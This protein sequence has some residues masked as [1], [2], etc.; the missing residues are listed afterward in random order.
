M[1]KLLALL[2]II[3]GC[4]GAWWGA[5]QL[6]SWTAR[7]AMAQLSARLPAGASLTYADMQ[8]SLLHRQVVLS[9]FKAASGQEPAITVTADR[10]VISGLP[11][12]SQHDIKLGHVELGNLT[13]TGP[14]S[15]SAQFVE[16]DQP[17]YHL[18]DQLLQGRIDWKAG[19]F[20]GLT[21]R[22]IQIQKTVPARTIA[23]DE[24]VLGGFKDGL[25][26]QAELKGLAASTPDPLYG[27]FNSVKVAMLNAQMVAVDRLM[28]GYGKINLFAPFARA[29]IQSATATDVMLG[30]NGED[31]SSRASITFT[32]EG[33]ASGITTSSQLSGTVKNMPVALIP[34]EWRGLLTKTGYEDVSGTFNL[35]TQYDPATR[36][37][38]VQPA[39]VDLE[40]MLSLTLSAGI[41]N[42]QIEN[43]VSPMLA[44]T[45]TMPSLLVNAE[46]SVREQGLIKRYIKAEADRLQIAPAVYVEQRIY[47]LQ[48]DTTLTGP[49]AQRISQLYK[50]IGS[51]LLN[52][53]ELTVSIA[54]AEPTAFFAL[55][56]NLQNWGDLAERVNL[57][58]QNRQISQP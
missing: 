29:A 20:A 27:E 26:Q 2:M 19:S 16:V 47:G 8:T 46:V 17:G 44:A 37:L 56:L 1:K 13:I 10:L 24:A 39:S 22:Q 45:Q 40:N 25:L 57:K 14:V 55:F 34:E 3:G 52:P 23:A 35:V 15:A 42:I 18:L 33:N 12:V 58:S 36:Q 49:G 5:E 38:H 6:L 51:F 31:N 32:A 48:P 9:G 7:Q 30:K 28:D 43:Y 21:A 50:S 11:W 41:G 4:V 53:G 54:P